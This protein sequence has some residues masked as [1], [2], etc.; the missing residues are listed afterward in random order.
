MKKK[1]ELN[2]VFKPTFV[3]QYLCVF[4]D[5]H[6]VAI[7]KAGRPIK[8]QSVD[9]I[10]FWKNKDKALEFAELYPHLGVIRITHVISSQ[11]IEMEGIGQR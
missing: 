2:F 8:A 10:K 9:K 1:V 3:N 11:V 7:N 4:N 5:G 6:A